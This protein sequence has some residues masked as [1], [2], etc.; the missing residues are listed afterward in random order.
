MH[1]KNSTVLMNQYN[2]STYI[3]S[4]SIS[5]EAELGDTTGFQ[6]TS[7]GRTFEAGLNSG[8]LS[9]SGFLSA[10]DGAPDKRVG[11]VLGGSGL[12]FSVGP[13][14]FT[15][16]GD[17]ARLIVG[18]KT[19]ANDESDR[20]S[21]V[22][23]SYEFTASGPVGFGHVYK[24]LG[25][26]S[27]SADGTA[28]NNGAATAGGGVGHIHA[29]AITGSPTIDSLIQDS[30]DG[31]TFATILTF[32]QLAAAGS[33]RKSTATGAAVRQYVREKRTFGGSGSMTYAVTFART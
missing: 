32:T 30:A 14:L 4:V 9:L 25:A 5:T 10:A 1:G 7:D 31:S 19:S 3:T 16:L 2:L 20:E 18:Q 13:T 8:S 23:D 27:A 33:E 11:Q 26:T 24:T 21:V 22:T 12:V 6:P 17:P 28:I 29:T 15:T